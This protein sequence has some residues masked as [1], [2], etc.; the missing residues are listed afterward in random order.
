MAE[1]I[2]LD[3]VGPC[4]YVK[5]DCSIIGHV[6]TF[7]EMCPAGLGYAGY[8]VYVNY[9]EIGRFTSEQKAKAFL[10]KQVREAASGV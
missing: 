4:F 2:V 10:E 9:K 3:G 6:Q 1:W 5:E 8:G 7:R